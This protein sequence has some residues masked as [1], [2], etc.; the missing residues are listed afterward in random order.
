MFVQVAKSVTLAFLGS[1]HR[2][3]GMPA[4]AEA[5][6]AEP[7]HAAV[8]SYL[9]AT[10]TPALLK[11][12]VALEKEEQRRKDVGTEGDWRPLLWLAD[13]FENDDGS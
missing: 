10:I 5:P 9:T 11:G 12:L 1:N 3:P 6:A 8:R 4:A 13:Y 7:A 2:A